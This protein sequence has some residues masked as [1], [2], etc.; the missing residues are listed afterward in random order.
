[1]SKRITRRYAKL[2]E[3]ARRK[4][5]D[6]QKFWKDM[7][8]DF[9]KGN[10]KSEDFSIRQLFESFV[11]DSAGVPCGKEII[12]SWIPGDG[13]S[14]SRFEESGMGAVTTAAFSNITGQIVYNE[15]LEGFRN[16]AFIADQ[17]TRT[18]STQFLDGEKIAG[19]SAVSD[20]AET[21]GEAQP[22]PLSGI[23]EAYV[24]TPRP[25]KRGHILPLTRET[26]IADRTGMLLERAQTIGMTMGINKE[27]RVLDTVMGVTTSWK[28]NGSAATATYANSGAVPHNFDNTIVNVMTDYTD[29][30]VALR[31]FDG[32][33][34]PE[35]NEPIVTDTNQILVPAS[36][37]FQARRIVNATA[38]EQGAIS[39]TVPRT[40]GPNPLVN[41]NFGGAQAASPL[42]I[43]TSPYVQIR[44]TADSG[45]ANNTWWIGNFPRAFRY[46]QIWPMNSTQ[47]PANSLWEFQN[48]IVRA[49]KVSEFGV[50]A[51]I[52]PRHVVEC[53]PS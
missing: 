13:H 32:F 1:M 10:V 29:I 37:L 27:K 30:D 26:I 48:D 3:T 44:I 24:E 16:P 6:E 53:T 15:T 8:A 52:E 12:D 20:E 39:A 23:T 25:S 36:L 21:V 4:P 17:L 43:L 40:I 2:Y 22:Y 47:L 9:N 50:P 38:I 46:M 31:Q 5:E 19:I 18:V 28:R 49:W 11:L 33:V 34:D 35:T 51:V 14:V 7:K 41:P 42:T 45:T